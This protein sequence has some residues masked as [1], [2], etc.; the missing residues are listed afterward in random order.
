MN[1]FQ[2]W[3]FIPWVDT[4]DATAEA[5]ACWVS[6]ISSLESRFRARS[7]TPFSLNS[8]WASAE[9]SKSLSSSY[10]T[11]SFDKRLDGLQSSRSSLDRSS[12]SHDD[13]QIWTSSIGEFLS[14]FI[15]KEVRRICY[16][17]GKEKEGK[18]FSWVML[19]RAKSNWTWVS[20][21]TEVR[22]FKIVSMAPALVKAS[23]LGDPNRFLELR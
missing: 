9:K 18:P 1:W 15:C 6:G 11:I 4:R 7:K 21:V 19:D 5:A 17:K 20:S 8:F 10:S 22:P 23:R 12:T 14:C 3:V 16:Q 13:K 2:V